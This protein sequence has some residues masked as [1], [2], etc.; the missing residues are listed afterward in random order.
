[1]LGD[2]VVFRT[3][4]GSKF[5]AAV[6]QAIIVF[7]ADEVDLTQRTGWSVCVTGRADEVRHPA[8]LAA[9]AALQLVSLVKGPE[10]RVVRIRSDIVTGRRLRLS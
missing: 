6:E 3:G 1:M 9:V 7:E 5:G 10:S 2:D 4:T 8:D